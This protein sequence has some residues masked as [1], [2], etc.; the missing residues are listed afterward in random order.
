MDERFMKEALLLGTMEMPYRGPALY[1][2]GEY[3][4]CCRSEGSM[5]WFCGQEDILLNGNRIY[6][7]RFHGG[8][9]R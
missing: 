9:I 3:V 6:E 8:K 1:R 5:D 4:Y 2:K 7:C